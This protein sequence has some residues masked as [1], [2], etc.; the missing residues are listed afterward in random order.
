MTGRIENCAES[1]QVIINKWFTS[2]N[3][4]VESIIPPLEGIN[5]PIAGTIIKASPFKEKS[6]K[7]GELLTSA[8]I[9]R[10]VEQNN[11]SNQILHI[12]S[13][14]IEDTK[15]SLSGRPTP[16]STSS[17]HNIETYPGFKISKFPK[18][19]FPKLSD[20]FEV[21]RNIIEKINAQLNNF[22]IS[23]KDDKTPKT[24]ST[25]QKEPVSAFQEKS[26]LLQ[27][28]ANSRFHN[29]KNYHNKPSFPDL[30]YEE[31]AF[32]STSSHE[33]RSITK[34]NIDGLAEHQVYNKLHEMG[35]AIIA[36]KMRGSA[37]RDAANMIIAGFTGMLKHWWGNYYTDEIK[38]LIINATATETVVKI[39][40]N[41]QSTSNI[42][43]EDAC[44][45][46]LYHIAKHFIG[47]PKLFQD[48]SL[49]ILSN[50]SCPNL[51]NFIH[52]KHAFLSKVMIRPYCNLDFWNERFISG[53]PPLFADKVRTKIQDRNNGNIPYGNLTYGDLGFLFYHSTDKIKK[54]KKKKSHRKKSRRREDSTRPKKK[55]SRSKRPND[56]KIDVCWTCGKTGHKANECCSKIK[57]KKI[58]ILN[59]DEET[60][61]TSDEYSDDEDI[62]LDYDSDVSQSGKDCTCTEAFC[63]CDST[64]HIRVLSDHSKEAL[65]DVIQ[66]IND[67]EARNHLRHEV[68]SLKKEIR[69]IKSRFCIIETDILTNQVPKRTAFHDLESNQSSFQEDIDDNV[70]IDLSNI[71]NDHLVKPF[72]TN[73]EKVRTKIQDHSN[74]NISYGNLTYGD[75]VITINVVVLELYT[76]IKLKHQLKKE[77]SSSR[78]EL[79]SF[80]RDFGFITP[81]DKIKKDKKEI[82]HRK[83]SRRRE[84][85]TRP[86]KK[87]S[88]SKRPIDAKLDVCWT[89]GKTGHKAN[90]CRS[91]TKKK[92]INILNTDEE[93]KG[94]LFAILDEPFSESSGTSD[95]YSDD[96][97]IDL[98]YD[99]DVSQSGKDCTCTEAFYSSDSTPHIRVLSD[100]SKEDLF[101]VIQH[102][103]DNEAGNHFFLELK[104]LL[105]NT[106][107]P[108]THLIIEPFSMKQIM[109]LSDNHFEPSISDLHHE[110]SSLKKEIR[111]IKSR[112]CIIEIDILTNQV[113]KRTTFHDLESNQ[114]SSHEDIDDNVGV[115]LSNI[116]NDHLVEPFVTNTCNDTSTS[117]VPG[118]T[119]WELR[120]GASRL[121]VGGLA[122]RRFD[123]GVGVPRGTTPRA[124]GWGPW[125]TMPRGRGWGTRG[126]TPQS[127]G[128]GPLGTAPRGRGW[129]PRGT[130]PRG[131]VAQR[132]EVGGMGASVHGASRSGG[133]GLWV[134]RL[135]VGWVG[136]SGHDAS[137]LSRG[138]GG[139]RGHG[140]W[141][142]E[143]G[144]R[145]REA[146]PLG[147]RG[148]GEWELEASRP[149][150]G[151]GRMGG[152]G[153]VA[154]GGGHGVG[155][156][157]EALSLEDRGLFSR[158]WGWG[159][160]LVEA[161]R[162]LTSRIG[163]VPR[164]HGDGDGNGNERW[165]PQ[166][167][168]GMGVGGGL[169]APC[170]K[171]VW[172]GMEGGGLE[173]GEGGDWDGW[174]PRASRPWGLGLEWVKA[175]RHCASRIGAL[176]R[177]R[178][179][180]DVDGSG[181][182]PRGR[183]VGMGVGGVLEVMGMGVGRGP[184]GRENGDGSGWRPRGRGVKDGSGRRPRGR[185]GLGVGL[186]RGL[187]AEGW[188]WVEASR[189][190][191]SRLGVYFLDPP[192]GWG[193]GCGWVEA[194]RPWG[195]GWE[196]VE[197]SRPGGGDGGGWRPRGMTPRGRGVRG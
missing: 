195:W 108:K 119:L 104:N 143:V 182:R 141:R 103:N 168:M 67:N 41:T 169:E 11:Y 72:V 6:D 81:P 120:H 39:E 116:N 33:G 14:Q 50:L 174:R 110:V 155:R 31:N 118:V 162:N 187:E 7:T 62:D 70:G 151:G 51:D 156:G 21:T 25:L 36:Y 20:T 24:V 2:S 191:A 135:V 37:D 71:N 115:D 1:L 158:L 165:M 15:P 38:Q 154:G 96:E 49:Q 136:A 176:S 57:K 46:L 80:C 16:A 184:R 126:T 111:N 113:P 8:D 53:L 161:S 77:Q 3:K 17:S 98:D 149:G 75:L 45:T 127:Q 140:A 42:T 178:G 197:A 65:F 181:W 61:G 29:M 145:A 58:N 114:S 89:C 157:L 177:G 144:G 193:Y 160:E 88:R 179:D 69:N 82:S 134:Q 40:G 60:K 54:D 170:L 76:D 190:D 4:V 12:I 102:I 163:A 28:L 73:T 150:R 64:P 52:Y 186:G 164:C 125:G 173:A 44:A 100:H 13:R 90:K 48:R 85:S 26:N 166:G 95:E 112:L 137:S 130:T 152:G 106:N 55:K 86:K 153:L 175:S 131:R 83:K 97:D 74:G 148:V 139:V 66:H 117:A 107:K 180:G 185:G 87:K 132:L 18:E 128:C 101:V 22:N 189:H 32:F 63:S 92:K 147:R 99:S 9:D 105:L 171:A 196:W 94:K 188:G 34:W 142:L 109:T 172:M 146:A 91:K 59:I 5:I 84:D 122:A 35:V 123:R 23:I 30:Q 124:R 133:G 159:W 167:R 183:G 78:K 93:T 27:K 47:E 138:G 10:V 192:G 79:G 19:K 68:S 43:R 56:A 121:G 129:G 194:S